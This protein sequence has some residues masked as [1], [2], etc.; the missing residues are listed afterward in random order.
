MKFYTQNVTKYKTNSYTARSTLDSNRQ[1]STRG[2]CLKEGLRS[3]IFPMPSLSQGSG[4]LLYPSAA[5]ALY[6][7][8][9]ARITYHIIQ[10]NNQPN[11]VLID[12]QPFHAKFARVSPPFKWSSALLDTQIIPSDVYGLLSTIDSGQCRIKHRNL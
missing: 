11:W 6:E 8:I 1:V 7:P 2:S 5:E 12:I 9:T 3:R 4:R 10:I